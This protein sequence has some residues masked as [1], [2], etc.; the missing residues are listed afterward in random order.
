L[1]LKYQIPA[2]ST[3]KHLQCLSSEKLLFLQSKAFE[4]NFK[5]R[6]E[7]TLYGSDLPF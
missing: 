3:K 2:P 5:S 6:F 7:S 4:T 1:K